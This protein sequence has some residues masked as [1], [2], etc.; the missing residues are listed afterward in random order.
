MKS[1]KLVEFT[2][3]RSF[4]FSGPLPHPEFFQ[5]YDDTLPGAA[6]RILTMAEK[7]QEYRH[8]QQSVRLASDASRET[9]GQWMAFAIV[10][11]ALIGSMTLIAFDKTV[12]GITTALGAIVGIV[13]VFISSK[14][15]GSRDSPPDPPPLPQ[16]PARPPTI[17]D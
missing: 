12:E 10:L 17:A 11:V 9:R 15:A 5:A 2:H 4:E 14:R 6:H 16:S 13:G 8:S 7:Q 1:Q 3:T